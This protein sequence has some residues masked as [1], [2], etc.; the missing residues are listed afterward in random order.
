MRRKAIWVQAPPLG[1]ILYDADCG[2]CTRWA[3]RLARFLGPR[4]YHLAP[5]QAPW[6][7]QRLALSEEELLC[8]MR[9][10]TADDALYGGADAFVFLA[11]QVWWTWPFALA[12]RLPGMMPLLRAG[13]R[14]VA[15]NRH[16]LSSTCALPHVSGQRGPSSSL[17]HS[18][19]GA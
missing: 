12:A 7:R 15:R 8:E 6:V 18:R 11:R 14:W 16:R 19:G 10:L 4:G 5:L 2:F 9:V 17:P 13:Y 1:W 3:W